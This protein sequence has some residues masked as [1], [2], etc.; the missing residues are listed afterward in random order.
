ML[1][2]PCIPPLSQGPGLGM[3]YQSGS[4]LENQIFSPK[5][6]DLDKEPCWNTLG[7]KVEVAILV[8]SQFK[9]KRDEKSQYGEREREK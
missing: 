4:H 6:L 8:M 9:G 3:K 2:V 7:A 5:A 1:I